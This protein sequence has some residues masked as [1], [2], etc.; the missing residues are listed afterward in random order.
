ME[1]FTHEEKLLIHK[2]GQK[3]QAIEGGDSSFDKSSIDEKIAANV[4]KVFKPDRDVQI[5]VYGA[6]HFSKKLDLNERMEGLNIAIADSKN[7]KDIRKAYLDT[8]CNIINNELPEYVYYVDKHK[9]VKMDNDVAKAE[10]LGLDEKQFK[11]WAIRQNPNGLIKNS[12]QVKPPQLPDKK[13]W[14]Q[15]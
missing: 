13:R 10:F 2:F 5:T 12:N 9:L 4:A 6:A 3:I 7:L 1:E 14:W 15:I 11:E 8:Q